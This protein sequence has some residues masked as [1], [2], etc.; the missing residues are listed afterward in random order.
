M[1]RNTIRAVRFASVLAMALAAAVVLPV[2]AAFAK[3]DLQPTS[4]ALAITGPGLDRPISASWRGSCFMLQQFA[5]S[6]HVGY[7]RESQGFP[8]DLGTVSGSLWTLAN[9]SN[10]LAQTGGSAGA[11]R[12]PAGD[13]GPTYVMRWTVTIAGDTE[14]IDQTLYPWGPAPLAGLPP[15]PWV[16]TP[17]GHSIF[18]L[19]IGSGW[20]PATSA[21]SRDLI[22]KGLPATAPALPAHR[23]PPASAA[24]AANPSAVA[25]PTAAAEHSMDAWAVAVG[26]VLLTALLGA[27]V[28]F[29]RPGR[30]T[31]PAA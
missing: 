2:H 30:R 31:Q 1:R 11:Y 27:G 5:C 22:S 15:V 9:D 17:P 28:T 25:L 19:A 29:G 12:A 7:R 20:M 18:E 6:K 23:P 26:V 13:L 14:V 3:G 24:A 16:Y 10:F 21:L 8:G 4:I